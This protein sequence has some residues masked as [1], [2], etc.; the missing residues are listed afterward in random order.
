MMPGL[1]P[2]VILDMVILESSIIYFLK[3]TLLALTMYSNRDDKLAVKIF[4][5]FREKGS[6]I[7]NWQGSK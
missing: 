1:L 2:M 6:I 5:H 4:N 3:K 7:H